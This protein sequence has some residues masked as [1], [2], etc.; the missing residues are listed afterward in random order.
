MRLLLFA[1]FVIVLGISPKVYFFVNRDCLLANDPA[2][3]EAS[4]QRDQKL[5]D[6]YASL[7]A[8]IGGGKF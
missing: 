4:Q 5:D 3:L 2:I 6:E 7:M 1:V 8:D